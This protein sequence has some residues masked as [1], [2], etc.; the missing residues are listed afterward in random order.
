MF[1]LRGAGLA[2]VAYAI[3][4]THDVFVKFLGEQYSTFQIIFFSVL[5]GFPLVTLM[6]MRDPTSGTLRPRHPVW[7]ALRTGAAVVTGASAFY[8]FSVLPMAQ[9]YAILFSAPLFITLLSIPILGE[10]VGIHRWAAVVVG[11][12]GV[13][14]VLRPGAAPLQQGHLAALLA[15]ACG[16]LGAIIVR[17]IG[18]DERNAVLLL[19]PMMASFVVMGC[20]VPFVYRAPPVEHLGIMALISALGV[21]GGL[22]LIS[23][24]RMAEAAL[25]APM[26]YS[27][28]IWAAA[29]G[30]F[31][32]DEVPSRWTIIGSAIVI[33]SGLY[34]VLRESRSGKS[35]TTPILRTQSR[36]DT[37]TAPRVGRFRPHN[38]GPGGLANPP[39]PE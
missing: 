28:I 29:F 9:V 10:K 2:L 3:F 32:F 36:L 19:Y 35:R 7:S 37:G 21:A 13:L 15:A 17:K 27:Q 34:I 1:S 16:S 24:Y 6:L 11:L 33:A 23:A 12:V 25:V 4:A 22:C 26:Q 20:L 8:A 38:S 14:V 30:F 18:R 39:P 31:F 5:L